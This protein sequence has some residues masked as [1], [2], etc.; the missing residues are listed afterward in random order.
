MEL[1]ALYLHQM[2]IQTQY[3]MILLACAGAAQQKQ[4]PPMILT[5]KVLTCCN[6]V[7][8]CGKSF[9]NKKGICYFRSPHQ[10]ETYSLG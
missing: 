1:L 9:L 4:C 2:I 8:V 5:G 6:S 10:I 7:P 3:L